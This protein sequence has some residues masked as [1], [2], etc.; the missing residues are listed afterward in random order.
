MFKKRSFGVLN[1]REYVRLTYLEIIISY[2]IEQAIH[3][4]I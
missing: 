4:C 2:S 3:I 1:G